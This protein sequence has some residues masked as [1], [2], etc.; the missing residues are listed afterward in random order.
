MPHGQ[1]LDQ[2]VGQ[3]ASRPSGCSP[4]SDAGQSW[5]GFSALTSRASSRG[6]YGA[7]FTSAN[8]LVWTK[9]YASP[10][11]GRWIYFSARTFARFMTSRPAPVS[12][13]GNTARQ[14]SGITANTSEPQKSKPPFQTDE[15]VK[16][17]LVSGLLLGPSSFPGVLCLQQPSNSSSPAIENAFQNFF[18]AL[19]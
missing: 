3:K 6:G 11:I 12:I 9:R 5:R 4:P 2:S 10:S 19:F 14:R 15:I 16:D 8:C 18:F 17:F 7:R 1:R 13:A